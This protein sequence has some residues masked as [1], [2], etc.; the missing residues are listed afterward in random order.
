MRICVLTETYPTTTQTFIYEPIDWLRSAG[1]EVSVIASRRGVVPGV[2]SGTRQATVIAPWLS[3]REKIGRLATSPREVLGFLPQAWSWRGIEGWSVSELAVRSALP[4]IDHADCVLAHFGPYGAHWLPIVAT[5][6][7]PYAVYF[8]GHDATA[9]VRNGPMAYAKLIAS[10]VG[11][12]TNSRYIRS[13]LL[14]LGAPPEQ[15]GIVP[16]AASGDLASTP[17]R[18]ALETHRLLTIA[19]LVPKKGLHDSLRAFALA[20]PALSGSWRYQIVGDGPLLGELRSLAA[21]LGI[22][23]LVDFSGFLSRQETLAALRDA[24]LFVL[25]SKT[26]ASGDTEGTP[27]S[28]LEAACVGLPV[29]STMH[30]G[31]PETLP[32]DAG[33]RG[34]LVAEGDVAALTGAIVDLAGSVERRR[35][36]GESCRAFNHAHHSLDAHVTS[37]V[38]ALTRLAKPPRWT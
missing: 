18:P 24:S 20:Q 19:R 17:G 16:L 22:S 31:I 3:W 30:G 25:A 27:V 36:W 29:I 13:L 12:L 1:H 9:Y 7:R 34:Y 2:A 5:A 26:A 37:L 10:G 33:D 32:A 11:L 23:H 38:E 4:E 28:I 35:E 8:H 14:K 6:G 21:S 15:V